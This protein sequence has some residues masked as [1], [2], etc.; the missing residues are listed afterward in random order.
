MNKMILMTAV[1]AFALATGVQAQTVSPNTDLYGLVASGFQWQRGDLFKDLCTGQVI[2]TNTGNQ[3]LGNI[4]YR[5]YYVSE[6]G[7]V[8]ENSIVDA[9]IE[10]LIQPGQT[11]RIELE[12][13]LVPVDCVSA[14][15]TIKSCEV[16]TQFT[17]APV[18]EK[19][20]SAPIPH[21]DEVNGKTIMTTP[22]GKQQEVMI[23]K[24][25]DQNPNSATGP[26]FIVK[27]DGIL[28]DHNFSAIADYLPNKLQ[29]FGRSA[30]ASWIAKDMASDL[31]N[32]SYTKTIPN[33]ATYS[34]WTDANG[35]LHESMQEET[36]AQE[37]S[38]K[39]HHAHCLFQIVRDGLTIKS[40]ELTVLPSKLAS[41]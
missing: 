15:M 28:N 2:F 39:K 35:L 17:A 18:T 11:R 38:G 27:I 29:Y 7:V 36:F 10:K 6:T 32:Y 12:K 30:T 41:K 14:G 26:D 1:A 24:S 21:I 16:L 25:A 23:R 3:A 34:S 22:D 37:I 40:L 33:P 20:D 31:R 19:F 5:T 13:F 9:V 8:H 4:H